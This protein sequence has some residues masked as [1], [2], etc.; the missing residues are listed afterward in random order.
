MLAKHKVAGSTPVFRSMN[1]NEKCKLA[2]SIAMTRFLKSGYNILTPFGGSSRYDFAIEKD[3]VFERVQVKKANVRK[4]VLVFNTCS[5]MVG[6]NK[7]KTKGYT[8]DEIDFF[9]AVDTKNY[10]VYLMNVKD[11]GKMKQSLRLRAP[12][13]KQFKGIKFAKDYLLK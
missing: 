1:V 4:D 13:N 10:R 2:E 6:A 3:G 7:I 11:A 5:T 12:K 9:A 8:S